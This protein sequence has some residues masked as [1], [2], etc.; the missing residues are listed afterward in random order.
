VSAGPWPDLL[1]QTH[2]VDPVT[3]LAGLAAVALVGISKGGL[4]GAFALMGVPVLA[5]VMPPVQ[6]A[7]VLLPLLLMMDV[8]RSVDLA[9]GLSTGPRF[10][11]CCPRRSWASASAGSRPP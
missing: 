4:G 7:A 11:R 8:G 5:L 2:F 10:G 9:G 6:A 1:A 3:L